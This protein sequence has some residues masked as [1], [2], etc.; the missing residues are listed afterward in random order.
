MKQAVFFMLNDY[1][2]WEGAYLSSK[3]NQSDDWIVKTVSINSEIT[4]IGGFR[5]TVDYQLNDI[6][7]DVD[8]LIL[9]G[10]NSW[11]IENDKLKE[12]LA[13]RLKSGLPTGS[14]CG[15]VDY[16]ARNGLLTV[17]KHTGNSQYLWKDYDAYTNKNDFL[18]EQAVWDDN[19]VT[20]NGTAALDFTNLVIKMLH[21]L[22]DKEANQATD[23]Y[24][25]GFY[26]FCDKYGNPFA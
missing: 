10:G 3:L 17:Y 13:K 15:S 22:S 12:L 23:L 18:M 2:D 20:A 24:K 26:K 11:S 16:L 21:L 5:T 6:S 9:I 4:S 1:A 8:L 7:D 14:I 25:L 19:L